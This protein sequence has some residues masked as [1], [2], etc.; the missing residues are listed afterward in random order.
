MIEDRTPG[1][2]MAPRT[3][4]GIAIG[5]HINRALRILDLAAYVT[6]SV[7][8]VITTRDYRVVKDEKGEY[9]FPFASLIS[10]ASKL[11]GGD[12]N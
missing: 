12:L 3:K 11:V 10:S 4:M 6:G 9:I 8:R 1:K 7:V 5:Y 2:K